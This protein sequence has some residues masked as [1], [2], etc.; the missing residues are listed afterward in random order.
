MTKCSKI[1]Q[2]TGVKPPQNPVSLKEK[3]LSLKEKGIESQR[4]RALRL[5]EKGVETQRKRAL[6]LKAQMRQNS[7]PATTKMNQIE[8]THLSFC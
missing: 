1:Q 3:A 2:K 4:K 8:P 5:K 6:R 7:E